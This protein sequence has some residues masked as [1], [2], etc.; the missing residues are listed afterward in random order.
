MSVSLLALKYVMMT[1]VS[2]IETTGD[3][4]PGFWEHEFSLRTSKS[5]SAGKFH[6][7][8]KSALQIM[9][10]GNILKLE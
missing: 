7:K 5:V 2:S 4:V 10:S 9:I 6:L 8:T 3:Y 1:N